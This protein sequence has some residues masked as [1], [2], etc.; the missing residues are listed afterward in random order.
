MGKGAGKKGTA[1]LRI[2]GSGIKGQAS[3]VVAATGRVRDSVAWH[4]ALGS[5]MS[6]R[7]GSRV[8]RRARGSPHA[9]RR[10]WSGA[11][12]VTA[13]PPVRHRQTLV[14]GCGTTA[15]LMVVRVVPRR[16]GSAVVGFSSANTLAPFPERQ[17]GGHDRG[18][19]F[20]AVSDQV[21]QQLAARALEREQSRARR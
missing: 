15:P 14:R 16:T 8:I 7:N 3:D 4:S 10:R 6:L 21:E 5:A 9:S 19:V 13:C 11:G 1:C 12:A 2:Y 17:I 20:V 18:P